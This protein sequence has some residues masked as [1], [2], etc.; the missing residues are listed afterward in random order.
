MG[1]EVEE[2]L[3]HRL[4]EFGTFCVLL[5]LGFGFFLRLALGLCARLFLFAGL[6]LRFFTRETLCFRSRRCFFAGDALRFFTCEALSFRSRR[7][8]FAGDTFRLFARLPL[9]FGSRLGF[10]AGF[11][12]F[13]LT[14]ATLLRLEAESLF[15]KLIQ[16]RFVFRCR[17]V[18]LLIFR[19][20]IYSRRF[21]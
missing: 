10:L 20:S 6:A 2:L 11:A 7:C 14:P 13:F 21:R 19:R 1:G 9:C 18:I 8:F 4:F 16:D 15:V 17:I 3:L 5:R 12:L